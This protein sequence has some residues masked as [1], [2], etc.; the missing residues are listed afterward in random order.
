MKKN[1]SILK[2]I[3]GKDIVKDRNYI[4]NVIKES[5]SFISDI[6]FLSEP[7][8]IVRATKKRNSIRIYHNK[9]V[10]TKIETG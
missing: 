9:N 8:T 6:T 5:S 3:K 1:V 2:Q 4:L 7:K 10:V